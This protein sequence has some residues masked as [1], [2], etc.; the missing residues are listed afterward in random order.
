MPVDH[1]IIGFV[2]GAGWS[3]GSLFQ[4]PP[5]TMTTQSILDAVDHECAQDPT[6]KIADVAA[7]VFMMRVS[8]K[9]GAERH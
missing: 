1:W 7:K 8:Q 2:S 5:R 4:S 6:A 9:S 3:S